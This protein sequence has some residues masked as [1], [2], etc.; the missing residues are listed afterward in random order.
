MMDKRICHFVWNGAGRD[1]RDA[2]HEPGN[3]LVSKARMG[4]HRVTT[5]RVGILLSVCGIIFF[6]PST[7]AQVDSWTNNI[8]GKWETADA[9]SLGAVPS[10]TQSSTFITNGFFTGFSLKDVV[11]DSNTV[12]SAPDSLSISNLTV[13]APIVHSNGPAHQGFNVLILSNTLPSLVTVYG[14]LTV[15]TGGAITITN[16]ELVIAG[17]E[18]APGYVGLNVDGSVVLES[19]TIFLPITSQGSPTEA[20]GE[21]LSGTLTV[22]GG[23]DDVGY[24]MWAGL[25]TGST[26]TVWITGGVIDDGG[27]SLGVSGTGSLIQSNG[28]CNFLSQVVAVMTGSQ[29]TLTVL[30]GTNNSYGAEGL[31]IGY[32]P[33]ATGSVTVAGGQLLVGNGPTDV[34]LEGVGTMTVS[35]G[36]WL[37]EG[38][39]VGGEGGGYGGDGTLTVAGG[40]SSVYSNLT[41][42]TPDCAGTGTVIIAGGSLL[43]TNAAHN[44]VL[45][46]ESGNLLLSG[47]TLVVDQMISTNPCGVFQQTGGTL[48]V[49]G[50]TN[51]PALFQITSI[52]VVGNDVRV[53][54]TDKAGQTNIVQATNGI[55]GNYATNFTDLSSPIILTGSGY[56]STNYLDVS[57]ATNSPSRFYRVRVG[58]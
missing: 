49:G 56:V 7:Q 53:T 50:V 22:A 32:S 5:W 43:V 51:L 52:A 33:G 27:T 9:W 12:V 10:I 46:L 20:I 30:G 57:G 58:P 38:V 17:L 31:V 2:G 45:D 28:V 6:T 8:G 40:L 34:G 48:V 15:S 36:T 3:R 37:A 26:G 19:G 42:G 11:I 24:D 14:T 16:S 41:I 13:S 23:L 4:S 18:A 25:N 21:N 1:Q 55:G 44:G 29:G 54:W 35:N 39:F 47:G